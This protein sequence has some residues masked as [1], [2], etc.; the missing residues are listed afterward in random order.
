MKE[1]RKMTKKMFE[2]LLESI[3]QRTFHMNDIEAVDVIDKFLKEYPE[4]LLFH[5]RD[6]FIKFC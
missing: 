2:E 4:L 5:D 6:W 3:Q 1:K